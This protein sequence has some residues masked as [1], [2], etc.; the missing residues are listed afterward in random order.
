MLTDSGRLER[1]LGEALGVR[2]LIA[3][4]N[5]PASD[6]NLSAGEKEILDSLRGRPRLDSWLTGRAALKQLLV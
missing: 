6:E 1:D 3:V 4:A 2:V 5:E